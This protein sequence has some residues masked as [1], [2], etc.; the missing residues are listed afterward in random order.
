[1]A[2][3]VE[4]D[5]HN[6]YLNVDRDPKTGNFHP[7]VHSLEGANRIINGANFVHTK[8][9]QP[10]HA[11]LTLV[12][13]YPDLPMEEVW[14]RVPRT[15]IPGIYAREDGGSR[16]VYFPFD[17]DRTFWEVLSGDHGVLLRNAVT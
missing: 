7:V 5:V 9:A 10:G 6:S 12:P 4:K 17:V 8:P 3:Q 1:F 11:P 13:S 2:G 16:V 14:A 15:D